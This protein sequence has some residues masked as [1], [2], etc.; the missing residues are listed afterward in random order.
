MPEK[1]SPVK[2]KNR[3]NLSCQV[4]QID[5]LH[6]YVAISRV[7]QNKKSVLYTYSISKECYSIFISHVKTRRI[8]LYTITMKTVKTVNKI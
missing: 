4:E 5:K 8:L 2:G 7:K 3:S 1:N 6:M